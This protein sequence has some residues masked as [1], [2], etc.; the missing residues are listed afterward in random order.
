MFSILN[1]CSDAHHLQRKLTMLQDS[2]RNSSRATTAPDVQLRVCP[3][4][5]WV[6]DEREDGYYSLTT[7]ASNLGQLDPPWEVPP[8]THAVSSIPAT[9]RDRSALT[10]VLIV[11]L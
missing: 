3:G 11:S 8:P 1:Q 2:G 5:W 4:C 10:S 6:P 7:T 9:T